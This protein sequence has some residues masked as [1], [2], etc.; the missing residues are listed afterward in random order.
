MRLPHRWTIL[1]VGVSC[2]FGGPATFAQTNAYGPLIDDVSVVSVPSVGCSVAFAD[3]FQRANGPAGNGWLDTTGNVN[4]QLV[5]RD[6]V[7][8]TSGPN[9]EAGV[10]RPIDVSRSMSR[11]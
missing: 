11:S 6:G 7:L 2:G 1:V 9:V 8:S 3:D 10:Y 5:L 4:G